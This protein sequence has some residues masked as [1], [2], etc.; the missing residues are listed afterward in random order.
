MKTLILKILVRPSKMAVKPL[1]L[2]NRLI[3]AL[4]K[5]NLSPSLDHLGLGSQHF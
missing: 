3:L 1:R 4:K 2:L 5:A